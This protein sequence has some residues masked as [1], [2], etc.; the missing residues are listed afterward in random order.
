M[1]NVDGTQHSKCCQAGSVS[2]QLRCRANSAHTRQSRP[3]SGMGLSHFRESLEKLFIFGKAFQDSFKVLPSRS[4]AGLH[5]VAGKHPGTPGREAF[6]AGSH[7]GLQRNFVNHP[8]V[9]TIYFYVRQQVTSPT[10]VNGLPKGFSSGYSDRVPL[11]FGQTVP[12]YLDASRLVRTLGFECR[13][14]ST[15][16]RSILATP[17]LRSLL[18]V[19]VQG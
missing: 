1:V 18:C 12:S 5:I 17:C 7:I 2:A 11:G 16:R 9:D 15:D 13:V 3:Y 10:V 4:A 8:H 19:W 6:G 14:R